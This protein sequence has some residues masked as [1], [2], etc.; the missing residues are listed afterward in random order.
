MRKS[1]HRELNEL[2]DPG[3]LVP[4]LFD[5]APLPPEKMGAGE[6]A[7]GEAGTDSILRRGH[8]CEL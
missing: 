1:S 2:P 6:E 3:I 7:E 4:L 8:F 5:G